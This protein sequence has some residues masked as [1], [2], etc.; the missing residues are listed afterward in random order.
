[1][2]RGFA[3]AAAVAVLVGAC[4]TGSPPSGSTSPPSGPPPAPTSPAPGPT[5]TI[6]PTATLVAAGDVASCNSS[7]DEATAALLDAIPG[8][9]A[10]LGD[11]AYPNG[12]ASD[13]ARCYQPSWGRHRAR[14]RPAPGNHEYRTSGASGYFGYFGTAAGPRGRGYY[15]YDLG[16]WHVVALNSN[17]STAGCAAWSGQ[18]RWLRADLAAAPRRCTLAYWHHPLFTSGGEHGPY[19]PVRPLFRVL[20]DA[21]AEVVLTGHNHNYERFAPLDPDGRVDPTG[22]IRVFV[23]GTGGASHYAFGRAV[24]RHSEARD[25]RAF[26]VL[27]LTLRPDGY[28]WEF[29]PAAGARFTDRGSGSCH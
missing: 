1:M 21:G 29:L 8:T 9:I 27:K 11:S 7:G 15:S 25:D 13:Y 22:G 26:G 2:R 28:D 18:E 23:V 20:H 19:N 14:T 24:A 12:S 16:A 5:P 3:V 6:P 10:V 4:S 17:C